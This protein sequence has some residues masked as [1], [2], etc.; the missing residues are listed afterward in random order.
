MTIIYI[1]AEMV[2]GEPVNDNQR[3]DLGFFPGAKPGELAD[4]PVNPVLYRRA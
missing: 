4:T 3:A 2:I 1:D